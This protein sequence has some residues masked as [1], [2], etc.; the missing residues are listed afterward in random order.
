M[1]MFVC[2]LNGSVC[3]FLWSEKDLVKESETSSQVYD[4]LLMCS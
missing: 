4:D 2:L 1:V 3:M